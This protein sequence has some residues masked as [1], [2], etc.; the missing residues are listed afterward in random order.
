MND[1]TIQE[2]IDICIAIRY[3]LPFDDNLAFKEMWKEKDAMSILI[4]LATKYVNLKNQKQGD[5]V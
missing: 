2:A 3:K 4:N 5:K 1:L